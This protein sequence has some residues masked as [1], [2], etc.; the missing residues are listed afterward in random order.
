MHSVCA[1]VTKEVDTFEYCIMKGAEVRPA[2]VRAGGAGAAAGA[3]CC[4]VRRGRSMRPNFASLH[5]RSP[6]TLNASKHVPL[7]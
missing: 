4:G 3:G 7:P 2:G 1:T 5:S 6:A